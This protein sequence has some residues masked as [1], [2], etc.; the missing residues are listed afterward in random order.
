MKEKK[1]ET[2]GKYLNNNTILNLPSKFKINISA[3]LYSN[4][5]YFLF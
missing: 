5:H 4:F 3:I 2:N 1:D